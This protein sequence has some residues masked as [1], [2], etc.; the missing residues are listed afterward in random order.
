[1]RLM[2]NLTFTSRWLGPFISQWGIGLALMLLVSMPGCGSS[3]MPSGSIESKQRSFDDAVS[4]LASHDY[5]GAKQSAAES[6]QG[7]GLT[8][9]QASEASM[10]LIEAAIATGDLA[11]A[12]AELSKVE[13]VAMDM[14]RVYVLR[15]QLASKQGNSAAAQEA[16]DKARAEDPNIVIPK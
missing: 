1:M 15:G 16:Y 2:Q 6:L 9:D 13:K 12:E 10:I 3:G 5:Q 14:A 8:P 7:G 11:E 4:R